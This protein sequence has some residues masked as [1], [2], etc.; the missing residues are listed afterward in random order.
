MFMCFSSY[1]YGYQHQ[2]QFQSTSSGAKKGIKASLAIR[3]SALKLELLSC[4]ALCRLMAEAYLRE[5]Y[6]MRNIKYVEKAL[7]TQIR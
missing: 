2:I 5:L 7:L 3:R 4:C 6:I 1:N